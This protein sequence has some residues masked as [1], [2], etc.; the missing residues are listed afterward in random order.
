MWTDEETMTSG[1]FR[2]IP[3]HPVMARCVK[4]QVRN[5]R[6]FDCAGIEILDAIKSIPF[7]LRL[8]LPGNAAPP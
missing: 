1:T 8:A 6:I 7:D 5:N 2:F 3:R 4:Y